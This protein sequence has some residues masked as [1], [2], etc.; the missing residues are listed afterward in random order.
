MKRRSLDVTSRLLIV[1]L[2]LLVALMVMANVMILWPSLKNQ[3]SVFMTSSGT[4]GGPPQKMQMRPSSTLLSTEHNNKIIDIFREAGVELDESE[5][6]DLPT[7]EDIVDLV[8]D[9]PVVHGLETCEAFRNSVPAVER[10]LGAA[11]MFN[12]GTNLVTSLLKQNCK[13][14]ERVAKYGTA[15]SREAHGIRWQV[16]WGK[17][18]PAH[19]KWDHATDHARDI[20]KTSILPVVTIRDPYKW[21][22]SMCKN[23]YTAR[24]PHNSKQCP[25][26][27]ARR[28]PRIV[29]RPSEPVA[30]HVTYAEKR[31]SSH[32]SLAHL[33][34]DWYN[35]YYKHAGY[36][37][38]MVRFEDLIF[39]PKE[40][41]KLI[42]ECAGGELQLPSFAY[43]V[44]P[45]KTGPGHGRTSERTGM[46]QAWI[47]YGKKPEIMG[48]F[49]SADYRAAREFLDEDL[50]NIFGY[51]HPP[52]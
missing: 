18:T 52:A 15:A 19:Y 6:L 34:N 5:L 13:I 48:G 31:S 30:V 47:R 10:N 24:W 12:T 25:H 40:M 27:V 39:Y 43:I 17:H 46:V 36:P 2:S 33:W 29:Q 49:Q 37:R 20:D 22:A 50:M 51:S 11:G 14:P 4:Q 44:N 35:D 28:D 21:M 26:L 41:T 9:S 7:W 23:G 45:A 8:G 32:N 16:S 38:L 1:F 42:C 3:N